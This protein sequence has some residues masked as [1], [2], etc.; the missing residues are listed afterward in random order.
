MGGDSGEAERAGEGADW[1]REDI[2]E[3]ISEGQKKKEKKEDPKQIGG[4]NDEAM[5]VLQGCADGGETHV[6]TEG[7]A[8]DWTHQVACSDEDKGSVGPKHGCVGELEHSREED[9]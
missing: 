3:G 7:V 1:C 8:E 9:S 4:E 5:G 6:V 2:V